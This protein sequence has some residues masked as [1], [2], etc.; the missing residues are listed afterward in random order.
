[1]PSHCV[2]TMLRSIPTGRDGLVVVG[3]NHPLLQNVW[4]D[5]A[6]RD[7]WALSVNTTAFIEKGVF[8]VRVQNAGRHGLR[9]SSLA[10]R[11]VASSPLRVTEPR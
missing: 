4:I 10:C 8:D 2:D 1:M 6:V 7:A 3:S 9:R 5:N 11:R